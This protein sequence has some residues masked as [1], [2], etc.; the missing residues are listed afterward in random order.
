MDPGG[1]FGEKL[2]ENLRSIEFQHITVKGVQ[3]H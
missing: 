3:L 1:I 2:K